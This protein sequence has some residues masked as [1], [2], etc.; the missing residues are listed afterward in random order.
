MVISLNW[1]LFDGGITSHD[2]ISHTGFGAILLLMIPYVFTDHP[3]S[4]V[5]LME[6][7]TVIPRAALVSLQVVFVNLEPVCMFVRQACIL[8]IRLKAATEF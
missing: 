1:V 5:K 2:N 3:L 7:G 4:L 8:Q 6:N